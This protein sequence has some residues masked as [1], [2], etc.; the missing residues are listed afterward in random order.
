MSKSKD[1]TF[2]FSVKVT[3][4]KVSGKYHSDDTVIR[5]FPKAPDRDAPSFEHVLGWLHGIR[6]WGKENLPGLCTHRW[7]G[8]I[9]VEAEGNPP[10]L[11]LPLKQVESQQ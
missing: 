3:Y 6:S 10:H 1:I 11:I 9:L 2:P 7:E 4:Y 5:D 8:Y